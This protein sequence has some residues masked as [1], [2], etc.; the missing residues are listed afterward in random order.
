MGKSGSSMQMTRAADYAVRALIHLAGIRRGER[1]M[2][3]D[4]ARVTAAPYSFLSKVMQSL[5]HAGL[6]GSQRGQCGGFEILRKGRN[7][8][9]SAVVAA[10]D[11]PIHLNLCLQP[12]PSCDRKGNCPVCPIWGRA[13]TAMLQVL[14]AHTIADLA[15]GMIFPKLQ[16]K[17]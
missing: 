1:V 5:C 3:P 14:D 8:R 16:K 15:A 12:G 11:G 10:V 13:Q 7:A 17:L 9:I 4:L 6:V 2:L